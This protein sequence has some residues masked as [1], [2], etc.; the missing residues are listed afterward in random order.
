MPETSDTR[1]IT[2]SKGDA[3]YAPKKNRLF[4]DVTAPPY[5][6]KFDGKTND[7]LAL[8]A[9]FDAGG[10][11]KL[12]PGPCLFD[13]DLSY[14]SYTVIDAAGPGITTMKIKDGQPWN[15][16]G[17]YSRPGSHHSSIGN[18]T[19]DGNQPKRIL[20]GG[21]GG[22][23]GTNI[24]IINSTYMCVEKVHSIRAVQ[25]CFDITTPSYGN[26]GDGAAILYPSEYVWVTDCFADDH[27]DDGFT[28]H[29]S[30][31][32][33]FTRCTA[34]GTWWKTLTKYTNANGFE[35]DDY[36]YD[37]TLT[38][39]HAEDN[40][41][42]FEIKAHGNMSA[43]TNVRLI[44]C[45]AVANQVN[46]SLRHIGHHLA[47][48]PLSKT[49]KNVQLVGCTSKFPK[50]VFT[51]GTAGTG[52]DDSDDG[53][54]YCSLAIGAYRGV[55]ITNFHAIGDPTY[56]YGGTS[57]IIFQ[58]RCEDIVLDGFHVE[59][60]TTGGA[61]IY[62][63]GGDQPAKNITVVNGML[64]D[65]GVMGIAM[66]SAAGATVQNITLSRTVAGS[67]NGIGIQVFGNNIVRGNKFLTPYNKN[68]NISNT[69]YDAY[70][71]PIAANISVPAP[72]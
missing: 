49:A 13:G 31:K 26:A 45:T 12:P 17:I 23:Y 15:T 19:M 33:W 24:S 47:T 9:A 72:A 43:A 28:T 27:G 57:Q 53:T 34:M 22:I 41:H 35:I 32:I 4:V 48:D 3:R 25:H 2:E 46:F 54:Y 44:G 63:K 14:G 69:Y 10:F 60:F 64:K 11:I 56:N 59:G 38:D 68:Y 50:K 70:E 40:A 55:T 61:D 71:T 21:S 39:C 7:T 52:V 1:L 16:R 42:G 62:S 36:S 67:P 51:G 58:Y 30:G 8:Q 66:G 5:N 65:S 18:F 29:G 6:A 20:T 37:V